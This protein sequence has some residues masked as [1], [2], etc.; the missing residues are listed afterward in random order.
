VVTV[1]VKALNQSFDWSDWEKSQKSSVRIVCVMV[2]IQT[3]HHLNAG[4]Y[5]YDLSKLVCL[6]WY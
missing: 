3:R 2:K 6:A 1:Y 5:Y 4:Q